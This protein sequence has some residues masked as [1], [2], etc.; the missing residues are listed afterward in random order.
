MKTYTEG[1]IICGKPLVYFD[2]A[3]T[4]RCQLCGSQHTSSAACQDGHFVCDS[5]HSQKGF[6]FIY[7][8]ASQ[9]QS[10]NPASIAT[11]MMNDSS[12]N[13]HGPEHHFLVAAA[14]LSAYKNAGGNID[15]PKALTAAAGRA[16]SVPGGICG[17][18]GACGAGIS[19]GI[20]VSIATGATP[21]SG[22]QWS[23]ANRITSQC[24]AAIADNGGPRCC[25]RN[26]YLAIT[27]A[28]SFAARHLDVQMAQSSGIRCR[29]WG[30]NPQCRRQQ[31]L[32]YGEPPASN[33]AASL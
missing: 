21:L 16:K 5:C 25:K 7:S 4:M 6:A 18:W 12:I 13:M 10:K 11:A 15:L 20:F 28:V 1:C 17:M 19:A 33:G 29:Y 31:C 26:T 14:L 24:L 9:T 32:Y 2:E 23:L 8:F 3:R 30:K 22:L 27:C